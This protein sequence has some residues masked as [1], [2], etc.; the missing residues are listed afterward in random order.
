MS[1]NVGELIRKRRMALGLMLIELAEQSGVSVAH[2]SRVEGG[3][4][5]ATA[6]TLLK[7]AGPLKM[8]TG[9][10]LKQAGLEVVE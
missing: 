9:E 7:L 2:L 3:D 8:K 6:D 10:L 1:K 5:T 4:R